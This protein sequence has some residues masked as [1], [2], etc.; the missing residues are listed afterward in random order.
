MTLGETIIAAIKDG[1]ELKFE[2]C[3]DHE[4]S[5]I[6]LKISKQ[7]LECLNHFDPIVLNNSS[8]RPLVRVIEVSMDNI[9]LELTARGKS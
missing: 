7:N 8:E 1:F 6:Q 4:W 3:I 5:E 2:P 9:K